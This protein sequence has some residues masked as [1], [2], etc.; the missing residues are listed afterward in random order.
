MQVQVGADLLSAS[1]LLAT[2]LGLLY[3]TWFPGVT[4]A[5]EKGDL[6]GP[7]IQDHQNTLKHLLWFRCAPLAALAAAF[8]VILA[9][10]ASMILLDL[11]C[12]RK[13]DAIKACF[14]VAFLVVVV[15]AFSSAALIV[16]IAIRRVE[17]NK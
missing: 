2:C 1:S 10:P 11:D 9:I 3:T 16:R 8:S 13:F 17:L 7:D 4:L 5:I 6:S 14:V 15:L 12:E